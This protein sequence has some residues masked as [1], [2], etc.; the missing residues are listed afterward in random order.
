MTEYFRKRDTETADQYKVRILLDK[1]D[2][3]MEEATWQDVGDALGFGADYARRVA[4][5]VALMRDVIESSRGPS[6]ERVEMLKERTR[7]R[8]ERTSFY[9]DIRNAARY[10]HRIDVLEE[11]I[12][13]MAAERYVPKEKP[14]RIA[15]EDGGTA[16][17]VLSDWHIGAA[18]KSFVGEFD[19]D[20]AR[21]ELDMLCAKVDEIRLRHG[22]KKAQV[23][24]LG[25]LISGN[26]HRGIDVS[27]REDVITQTM[28]ASEMAT[29]FVYQLALMF[30]EVHVNCVSG[31]HS[32]LG[33]KD[34][35]LKSERLDR[36]IPWYMKTALCYCFN[37]SVHD[38]VDHSLDICEIEGEEFFL[39]HG[40]YDA[41]TDSGVKNLISLVGRKPYGII[42]AHK[43]YPAFMDASGVFALQGGSLQGAGDPYSFDKRL[44]SK[45]AS[46][47]VAVMTPDGIECVYPV[48]LTV[49]KD[50][51]DIAA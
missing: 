30:E 44:T 8:D 47:T 42:F 35:A 11:Y 26:I 9:K 33:K 37:V 16:I 20:I 38:A 28:T 45:G 49:A 3:L 34:D 36:I 41:F 21:K 12:R 19:P 48:N 10:E 6:S 17:I 18:F 4:K 25:D 51:E 43:H 7:A 50:G 23:A 15:S 39:I 1:E 24:I 27:N 31:N 14:P 46:Q 2:G 40:D 22:L 5:G 29:D 13:D 32:R